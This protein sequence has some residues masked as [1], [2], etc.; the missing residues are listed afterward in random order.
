MTES[1]WLTSNDPTAM[2]VTLTHGECQP[3]GFPGGYKPSARKLQLFAC[4]RWT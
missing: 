2:L 3:F 4:G 1:E